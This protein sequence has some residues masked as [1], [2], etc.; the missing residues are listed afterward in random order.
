MASV[1]SNCSCFTSLP[2]PFQVHF[3]QGTSSLL[4]MVVEKIWCMT[5]GLGGCLEWIKYATR[6]PAKQYPL[7]GIFIRNYLVQLY[8]IE[9]LTNW[10]GYIYE[11]NLNP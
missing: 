3:G 8:A 6:T 9:P 10:F 7:V 11:Y 5:Q 1:S 4:N 2:F